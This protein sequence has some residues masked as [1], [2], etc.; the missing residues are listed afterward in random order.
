MQ[1]HGQRYLAN[2]SMLLTEHPLLPDAA[3]ANQLTDHLD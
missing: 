2:C 3:P 1:D